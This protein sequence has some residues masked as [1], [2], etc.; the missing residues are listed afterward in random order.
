MIQNVKFSYYPT[1]LNVCYT[2]ID[3]CSLSE[4]ADDYYILFKI[5]L[6]FNLLRSYY[7]LHVRIKLILKV[8]TEF[9]LHI[10]HIYIYIYIYT[11]TFNHW[12]TSIFHSL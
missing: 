8:H 5:M 12:E 11:Y 10:K 3:R 1:I 9:D 2:Y 4:Y 6:H 7:N